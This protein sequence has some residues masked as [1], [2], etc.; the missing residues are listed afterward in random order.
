MTTLTE[1]PDSIQATIH[2]DAL[3]RVPDFFNASLQDILTELLQNARRSGATNVAITTDKDL[4]T[5]ADNGQGILNPQALLAFGLSNWEET[6]TRS[7][8]PAGMGIYALARSGEVTIGSRTRDHTP[9]QVTLSK[10]HFTGKLPAPIVPL[11]DDTPQGTSITF[12][13]PKETYTDHR[14]AED[15]AKHFPLPVTLNG[16]E[17]KRKDFL[18]NSKHIEVWEGLRLGVSNAPG[19]LL[20]SPSINFHGVSIKG[21]LPHVAT[22]QLNWY[23]SIDVVDCPNLVLTLPARKDL[24]QT[25][26]IEQMHQAC[27][28][29]IYR[30]IL[31]SPDPTDV[32]K[33]D[34]DHARFLGINLPPARPYLH[35][36][37]PD[38]P[39]EHHQLTTYRNVLPEGATIIDLKSEREA[40]D[41]HTLHRAAEL[42]GTEEKLFNPDSDM[43]GYAWYD[44]LPRI[45]TF[46][47]SFYHGDQKTKLKDLRKKP[48]N[49]QDIP[50]PDR[51]VITLKTETPEGRTKSTI[52]TDL[53]FDEDEVSYN[54]PGNPILT[55]DSKITKAQL[56]EILEDAYFLYTDSGEED[57]YETEKERFRDIA[58]KMATAILYSP[59]EA[60]IQA[61][62]SAMKRHVYYEIPTGMDAVITFTRNGKFQAATTSV[63]LTPSKPEEPGEQA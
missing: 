7:E 31:N 5:V 17:L 44:A 42:R 2:Q 46:N 18:Q 9:W 51:V 39:D 23:A 53:C 62:Q 8:H 52:E 50:T 43:E 59:E 11:P 13:K 38:C 58:S 14:T 36:W 29:A 47:I 34:Y 61:I 63:E 15:T 55:K 21:K 37:V 20:Q 41:Q 19:H 4:Y 1:M 54:E 30:A 27:Y 28:R 60:T 40:P 48:R 24:V 25:P 3:E 6:L 26:F 33:K 16:T 22:H 12:T 56:E 49:E 35:T 57:S 32:S 45:T 10:D